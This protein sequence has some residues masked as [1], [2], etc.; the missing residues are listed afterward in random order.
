M[1]K[2]CQNIEG[3]ETGIVTSTD[4]NPDYKV[5][6]SDR[7]R[8]LLI[9]QTILKAR[10]L[11]DYPQYE[12]YRNGTVE[13]M[14][15]PGSNSADYS[16]LKLQ[17]TA[18]QQMNISLKKN[19]LEPILINAGCWSPG[20]SSSVGAKLQEKINGKWI[21]IDKQTSVMNISYCKSDYP[22]GVVFSVDRSQDDPRLRPVRVIWIPKNGSVINGQRK[23][24]A[25]CS[26]SIWITTKKA[27]EFD[28]FPCPFG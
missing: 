27:L 28:S 24:Y 23:P 22:Q 7:K 6:E 2:V 19:Y 20:A 13:E 26:E 12:L 3:Y 4:T 18:Y 8:Y 10:D 9:A 1:Q 14:A 11:N 5:A 16:S 15:N 25:T 17:C 21:T